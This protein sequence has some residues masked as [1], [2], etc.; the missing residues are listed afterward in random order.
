MFRDGG[1]FFQKSKSSPQVTAETSQRRIL[2]NPIRVI[3]E[4][5]TVAREPKEKQYVLAVKNMYSGGIL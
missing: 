5:N 3:P 1:P 4:S 2:I